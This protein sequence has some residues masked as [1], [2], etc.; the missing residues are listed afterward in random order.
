MLTIL[1]VAGC[2]AATAIAQVGKYGNS[3]TGWIPICDNFEKFCHKLATSLILSYLTAIC[4][5]LLTIISANKARQV[6]V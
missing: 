6:P 4:Y 2:G 5:L 3:Y 1:L